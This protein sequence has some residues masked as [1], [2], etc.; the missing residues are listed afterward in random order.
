MFQDL[1]YFFKIMLMENSL[2]NKNKLLHHSMSILLILMAIFILIPRHFETG[3]E[4][5][6]A[7]AAA[8]I[9]SDTGEWQVFSK[10]PLY[11][12][13]LQI[14]YILDYP[15]SIRIE[16]A[17]TNFFS[18]ISI[19][20]MLIKYVTKKYAV[21]LTIGWIPLIAVTEGGAVLAGIG[22]LA[23]YLR[24][25]NQN[26]KWAGGYF[27][28]FLGMAAFC[29][30]AYLPF[31]VG[32]IVGKFITN[33]RSRQPL[34][35]LSYKLQTTKIPIYI[36]NTGLL[37]L[38][39]LTFAF[40]IN[41]SN[42]HNQSMSNQTYSPVPSVDGV[43]MAFFQLGHIQWVARNVD[44]PF[45]MYEDWFLTHKKSYGGAQSILEAF[46]KKPDTV[47]KNLIA[48]T[49]NIN[50]LPIF[51]LTGAKD[52][53]RLLSVNFL[54]LVLM[55]FS[56]VGFLL[57]LFKNNKEEQFFS[58]L[59]GT[60]GMLAV[61]LLTSFNV[62]YIMILLPIALLVITNLKNGLLSVKSLLF[63]ILKYPIILG[64]SLIAIALITSEWILPGVIYQKLDALYQIELRL[65]NILFL[66]FGGIVLLYPRKLQTYMDHCLQ[67]LPLKRFQSSLILLS[68]MSLL[69]FMPYSSGFYDHLSAVF[70]GKPFLNG[71]Q[72][73]NT[74]SMIN[75]HKKVLASVNLQTRVLALEHQWLLAFADVDPDNIFQMHSLPPF[76]D[77]S[78]QVEQYLESMDVIL[79]S[80][81]FVSKSHQ[82]GIVQQHLR[83]T[84]HIEPFLKKKLG[85]GWNVETVPFFGKIY[86]R[87]L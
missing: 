36:V 35:L 16:Y 7:W 48:T 58:I 10:G 85:H 43:T 68:A 41:N 70:Q 78:G 80:N 49:H 63:S 4:S 39:V 77:H 1:I 54:L 45:M 12:L 83:Y 67:P 46:K 23:L 69:Y 34:I 38:L 5:W 76:K 14:F 62:R 51:F 31:F 28:P 84:Y 47:I 59:V 27:P 40:P 61:M 32:H 13:Y 55:A 26:S 15:L 56:L 57:K 60:G 19:Y 24:F 11:L 73:H 75:A 81:T 30:S 52:A 37:I 6:K 65:L 21:V 18:I 71:I 50:R 8:K 86:S 53:L 33:Y 64:S 9:L 3:G 20:Y 29:H 17:I 79:V 82:P 74:F 25:N 22:F 66:A 2:R 87:A 44:D 42:I 72:Q